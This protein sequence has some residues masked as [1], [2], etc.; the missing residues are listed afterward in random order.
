V[1]HPGKTPEFRGPNGEVLPG[2]IAEIAY[3]RLGQLD[4]WVMIRGESVANAPL[5][6]LHDGPGLSEARFF[7]IFNAA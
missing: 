3:L 4:Q 5:I 2:S 1:R 7:R 6:L